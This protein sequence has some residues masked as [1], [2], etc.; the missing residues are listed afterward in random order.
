MSNDKPKRVVD[1]AVKHLESVIKA[2]VQ[3]QNAAS[4]LS[5]EL[6]PE[7]KPELEPKDEKAQPNQKG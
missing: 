5:K 7:P 6:K 4:G 1:P 3:V 2:M